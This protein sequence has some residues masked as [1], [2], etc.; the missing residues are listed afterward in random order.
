MNIVA[1]GSGKVASHIKNTLGAKIVGRAECDI[2]IRDQVVNAVEKYNCRVVIN[3]AAKTNLEFCEENKVESFSSNTLGPIVLADVCKQKNIK[4]VH[5]SSGCLF[6]GNKMPMTEEDTPEP[7][8]WYTR[9]KLWA[10]DAILNIGYENILI[11][12]PRQLISSSVKL[13]YKILING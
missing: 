5:I 13:T 1:F 9:T 3:C 11:V 10:D 12:R 6:D 4:L 8:V 2:T 7:T